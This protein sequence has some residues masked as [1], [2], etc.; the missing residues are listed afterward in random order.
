MPSSK[1]SNPPLPLSLPPTSA[2]PFLPS[3]PPPPPGPLGLLPPQ[4]IFL[5]LVQSFPVRLGVGMGPMRPEDT[6][7][8]RGPAEWAC[9]LH[10]RKHVFYQRNGQRPLS[11]TWVERRMLFSQRDPVSANIPKQAQPAMFLCWDGEE[12]GSYQLR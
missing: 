2:S 3:A 6:G 12:M 8:F 11:G 7:P 1:P 5:F 4:N 9:F 10:V